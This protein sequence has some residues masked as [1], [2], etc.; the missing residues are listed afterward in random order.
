MAPPLQPSDRSRAEGRTSAFGI[1][2]LP[3]TE[4]VLSSFGDVA[5]DVGSA[6]TASAP[7]HQ[8]EGDDAG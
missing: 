1:A 7:D 8:R 4:D 3:S 6:E 5:S 2:R